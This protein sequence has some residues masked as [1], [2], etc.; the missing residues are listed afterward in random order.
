[1]FAAKRSDSCARMR[2]DP[3]LRTTDIFT[4]PEALLLDFEQAFMAS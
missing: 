1:V 3:E 2:V 4:N